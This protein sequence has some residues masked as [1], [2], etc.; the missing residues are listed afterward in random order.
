[1]YLEKFLD[2]KSDIVSTLMDMDVDGRAHLVEF[3]LVGT[4]TVLVFLPRSNNY[5][6]LF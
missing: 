4:T 5:C 3:N 1:M 2:S 6:V